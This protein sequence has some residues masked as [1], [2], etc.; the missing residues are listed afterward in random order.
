LS[1]STVQGI[2]NRAATLIIKHEKKSLPPSTLLEQAT[3]KARSNI[4]LKISI[5]EVISFLEA[6][7]IDKKQRKKL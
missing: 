5:I 2:K 4:K 1:K 6:Y 7:I 3:K